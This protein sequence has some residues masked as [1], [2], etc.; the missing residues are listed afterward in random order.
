MQDCG[1]PVGKLSVQPENP[2][3]SNQKK[4]MASYTDTLPNNVE[5]E[6]PSASATYAVEVLNSDHRGAGLS[7]RVH[8][9]LIRTL[10]PPQN[11]RAQVTSE[12]VV[13]TWTADAA[14]PPPGVRYVFRVL[15]RRLDQQ[16][17]Q[18]VVGEVPAHN[19][20]AYTFADSQIEWQKTYDYHAEAVTLITQSNKPAIPVEGEDTPTL[21]VFVNDV[22]PPAVPAGLQA[23]FSGPGQQRFI[24]LVWAPV[25]DVDL[26]GYNIYRHIDGAPPAK[27]NTDLVKTPA[28]RDAN[29]ESGKR[30]F[31]SVTAVDLRGNE[32][33]KSE[34]ASEMVPQ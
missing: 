2:A 11:F 16:E 27:I 8:V 15:R 30:Y 17:P 3:A 14:T 13:L 19:E 26:A 24:D 34:E 10:P 33:A 31:Y 6:N 23:V 32:S 9:P 5:N 21:R 1:T 18:S 22:F 7:N 12:G 25:S 20:Q 4:S 28:Y 29:V